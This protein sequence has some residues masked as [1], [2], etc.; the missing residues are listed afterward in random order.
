M[1]NAATSIPSTA[2]VIEILRSRNYEYGHPSIQAGLRYLATFM[3]HIVKRGKGDRDATRYPVF[4]LWGLTRF[5]QGALDKKFD[6]AIGK[7]VRWLDKNRLEDGGWATDRDDCFSLTVTM[8]TVHAFDRLRHH[9]T[10]GD[11]A[12]GMADQ[13]RRRVVREAR[14]TKASAWWTP[15]G[16]GGDPSGA[17]T[18]MA[19]LTLAA[20]TPEQRKVARAGIAWLIQHPE[21]WVDRCE[22]D[23]HVETRSWQMLSFSLGLRA[24]LHPCADEAPPQRILEAAIRHWDDLWVEDPGAWSHTRGDKPNTSGSFGV[25]VAARALKRSFEFD[26]AVHLKVRP[27]RRRLKQK[28][29]ARF[30]LSLT[31]DRD[32][33]H[34]KVVNQIGHQVVDT[35]IQGATQWLMLKLVTE[36]HLA[37]QGTN[38]QAKQTITLAELAAANESTEEACVRAIDRVNEVL[39]RWA[40]ENGRQFLPTLI[41]P[42]KDPR[43]IA[44]DGFGF[45]QVESVVFVDGG[46]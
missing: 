44:P 34:V 25:M 3:T 8:P 32:R 13:A 21:E 27:R 12:Q 6:E 38:D 1:K 10:Y 5:P 26:P 42:I 39:S 4:A 23:I 30:A 11:A 20:G 22:A 17:T 43:G 28:G 41:E 29:E 35:T 37:G 24:I 45:D 19:V 9:P 18:A 46:D 7:A 14:G 31:I 15:Y 33:R 16:D 2:H 36:R 40:K